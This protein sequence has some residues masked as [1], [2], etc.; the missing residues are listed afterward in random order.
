LTE[1]FFV[2]ARKITKGIPVGIVK[3][4]SAALAKNSLTKPVGVRFPSA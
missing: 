3:G 1:L 2:K 4:F